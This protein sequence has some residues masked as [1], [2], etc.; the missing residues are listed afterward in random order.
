MKNTTSGVFESHEIMEQVGQQLAS[1]SG[2][3]TSM[4]DALLVNDTLGR[5]KV[6]VVLTLELESDDHP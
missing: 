2:I 1:L 6:Q 3:T 5:K 4:D